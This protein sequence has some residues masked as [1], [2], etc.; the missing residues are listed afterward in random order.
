[1]RVRFIFAIAIVLALMALGYDARTRTLP[2]GLHTLH[3][4]DA[5][6]Q[7]IHNLGAG[8][9]VQVLSW[10]EIEP[11]PGEFHWEY[12][13]WLVRAAEYYNLR[14][15]ARLDKTPRWAGTPGAFNAVPYHVEDY[16]AFVE[17]VAARYRG[18]IAAYIVWNEPNISREWGDQSPDPGAYATILKQAAQRIRRNDPDA[19]IVAA[20]LA[21]TNEH[22]ERAMDDRDYLRALYAD[23]AKDSFDVLAAHPYPSTYPPEDPRGAHDGSNFNRLYDWR[24]IMTANGDG[25][26]PIW[27]TEFGYTTQMPPGLDQLRVSE[28]EQAQWIPRA[29]EIARDQMP[30]VEMFGVWN[31]AR[32]VPP[33]DE[34]A[35]Y[36]LVR[37]DGSLKPAYATIAGMK[38]ES[39]GA[40][41]MNS[42][43]AALSAP[44]VQPE[45]QILARDAIVHLGDSEYPTPWVPLYQTKNP[46]IQWTGEFYLSVSDL[47]RSWL[48]TIETMQVNDFDN[49]ILVNDQ[50]VD[51]PYLPTEDFTS[52]WVTSRF[53]IPERQLRVGRNTLTVRI[54]KLF[55]AFQQSGFTWDDI[56]VRNVVLHAR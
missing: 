34:L 42:I 23:D 41:T 55:P 44:P 25:A 30:F 40:F 53:D 33:S 16:A 48:L 26:K 6:I 52:I 2:L 46:S 12:T 37:A 24:D 4:A 49:R 51:P 45:H 14:V 56:Q 18:R 54:G 39:L 50:V 36:S 31:I 9:I 21:P 38:K 35:G 10:R 11:S 1:M 32:E 29:Y 5:D 19:R 13:D 17:R 22:S 28:A 3:A 47:R 20:G 27:I 43:A 15:V 8:Y 7:I